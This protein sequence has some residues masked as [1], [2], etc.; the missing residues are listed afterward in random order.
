MAL[1]DAAYRALPSGEA[2]G[3]REGAAPPVYF[4]LHMPRTGGNT[5]AGHLKAHLGD[6]MCSAVRPGPLDMLGRRR[7]RLDATPDF[8]RVRAVTGHYL[9]RSLERR[10]A[11]R[12]IRRTLLLRDPVG[13]HVSYYNHRMMFSLT[14]GG[15]IC[16]FARHLRAQPRDLVPLLLLWYWLEMPLA[17]I[18]TTGDARKYDR[19]NESLAGFWFVGSYEDGDLLLKAVAADLGIPGA[20]AR[21]NTTSEWR[22]R[23]A[24]QPLR[25]EDLSAATRRAILAK[26]PI[27][28]ALWQDWRN[29]G[30]DPA[31]NG[32]RAGS[33]PSPAIP[34]SSPGRGGSG[35][36]LRRDGELG[37]G[38]L[39]RAVMADRFIAPIWRRI[40]RASRARDWPGAVRLYRK[41]LFRVPNAPEIWVQYGHA[42]NETGDI[43]GAE[44]AY[45]RAV[46]LAPDMAE[47]H[48]FLGQALARQGRADEARA[49][50]RRAEQLDPAAL[51]RKFEE[52]VARGHSREEVAAYWRALTGGAA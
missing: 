11:G 41:A 3:S 10:F 52:L 24:W 28:D 21:K 18:L 15:P 45:R 50:L 32:V 16:D 19:L 5:I 4:L 2:P 35:W 29:A 9:G 33:F 23:V 43:A 44:A 36:E 17:T 30:F 27:H 49:A 8:R 40:G 6:R 13:F 22:R 42:L 1:T 7:V 34:G 25:E 14:R 47:W 46:V 20:A 31:R 37:I 38:D 26:N 39:M 48:L 51:R 12:E